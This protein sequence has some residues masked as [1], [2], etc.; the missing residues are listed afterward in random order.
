MAKQS[1]LSQTD[2]KAQTN[3]GR[4][5]NPRDSFASPFTKSEKDSIVK[6]VDSSS[7]LDEEKPFMHKRL[8]PNFDPS[9]ISP[10]PVG[11]KRFTE[12]LD[13]AVEGSCKARAISMKVE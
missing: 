13:K 9:C 5:F 3:Y 10:H 11:S 8:G 7:S 1:T 6:K 12:H 4:P 2:S